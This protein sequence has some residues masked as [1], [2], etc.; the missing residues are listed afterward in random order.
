MK[1]QR[2][3]AER[4]A[5][6]INSY[7]IWSRDAARAIDANDYEKH[8]QYREWRNDAMIDLYKEFGIELPLLT[9]VLAERLEKAA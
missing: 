8:E 2:E 4:I 5:S 6:L 3:T 1:L 9:S 7:E